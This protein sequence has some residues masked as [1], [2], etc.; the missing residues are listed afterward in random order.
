MSRN[1]RS[2]LQKIANI[3]VESSDEAL[4]SGTLAAAGSSLN[5]SNGQLGVLSQDFDG[6]T[7]SGT[8]ITGA[9]TL[10]NAFKIK[11]LQGTPASDDLTLVDPFQIGP[12]AYV[13]SALLQADR[14]RSVA[15][16]LPQPA[17]ASTL[18]FTDLGT[19]SAGDEIT[20]RLRL[21]STRDDRDYGDNDNVIN[22]SFII[23]STGVTDNKDWLVQKMVSRINSRSVLTGGSQHVVAFAIDLDGAGTG[24]ALT[25]LTNGSTFNYFTRNGITYSFNVDYSFVAGV[26]RATDA[27]VGTS[28]LLLTSEIQVASE[29]TAGD[30]QGDAILIVGLTQQ[31]APYFDNIQDVMTTVDGSLGEDIDDSYTAAQS[32]AKEAEGYGANWLIR[33]DMNSQL[34]R[35]TMQYKPRGE[36]FSKGYD[37]LSAT[38][39]YTSTIIDSWG[40]SEQEEGWDGPFEHQ[41]IILFPATITNQTVAQADVRI[42]ASNPPFP[43]ATDSTTALA[44]LEATLGGWLDAARAAHGITYVGSAATGSVFS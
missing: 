1:K 17:E 23:P 7:A 30:L 13:G 38:Q 34:R 43:A 36:F 25:A 40:T 5:V 4:A 11:V 18:V 44:A 29:A 35:H 27:A 22:E 20:L 28:P 3:L 15:T 39:W 31:R 2:N 21:K 32:G 12:P 16:Q 24:T 8:F 14:I 42:A 41:T 33:S 9:A 37:Y 6:S 10:A 19:I 26:A